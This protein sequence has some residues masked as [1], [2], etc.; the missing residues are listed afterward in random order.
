MHGLE[1]DVLGGARLDLAQGAFVASGVDNRRE[2]DMYLAK[3]EAL[4]QQIRGEVPRAG[5][6]ETAQAIFDWLWRTKPQ[7]YQFRGNY[8]LTDVLNAQLDPMAATVGNCLGLTVLYNLVA[9]GF[10]LPVK[11]VYVDEA[12]GAQSH[13]LSIVELEGTEIDVDNIFP[14]GFDFQDHLGD[15]QRVLWGDA[16]LISDIYHSVGWERHEQHDLGGAIESYS[17]AI[18]LNP[19]YVKAHLN[20]GIAYAMMGRDDEARC[21]FDLCGDAGCALRARLEDV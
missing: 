8:R 10:G 12:F 2:M 15:P 5:W 4:C 9:R 1:M 16:E 6:R 20:R 7:R 18:C 14:G 13:V 21:D 3:V 17:K 11:A 19:G